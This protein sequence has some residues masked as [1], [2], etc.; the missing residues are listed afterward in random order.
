MDQLEYCHHCMQL[1]QAQI[2]VRCRYQS[3]K[4][5]VNTPASLHVNGIK[6]FNAET[7]K[8]DLASSLILKKLIK[9]K[10]RRHNVEKSLE[11]T[12]SKQFCSFCL[13]NFY[14]TNFSTIRKDPNW[15]CPHC[16]GQCYCSRCRR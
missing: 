15:C 16:M 6:V 9:D 10:K 3:S 13:K 5:R 2:H 7:Y 11:I 12:C 4:H 1:K 14:D 8:P